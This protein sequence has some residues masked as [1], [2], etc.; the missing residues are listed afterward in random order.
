MN[1]FKR[2]VL[3]FLI[4]I[5]LLLPIITHAEGIDLKS[6]AVSNLTEV[7]GYTAEE[8]AQFVFDEKED[9]S[10][11]FWHPDHPDWIY[12]VSVNRKTGQIV[13]TSP[14]DTG[15]FMFRGENAVR[16]LMHTI[17]EKGWFVN[18]NAES[19]SEMLSFM[20]EA[21]DIRISTEL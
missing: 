16:V 19:R 11:A 21:Y 5:V 2:R 20:E 3:L 6:Y 12:T 15:Y 8:A 4:A 17:R 13:G 9:G 18:W 1:T 7:L 10:I 14:F